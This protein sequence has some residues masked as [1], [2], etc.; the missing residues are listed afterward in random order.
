MNILYLVPYV[1]SLIR[2]RPYNLIRGLSERGH[3]ITLLTLWNSEDEHEAVKEL[4]KYCVGVKAVHLPKILSYWNCLKSLPTTTPLQAVYCWNP[5]LADYMVDQ[6][7]AARDKIDIVHVEHLRGAKYGLF[8]KERFGRSGDNTPPV[9]WDS[10]DSISH[11]FRQTVAKTENPF[12]RVLTRFELRRTEKYERYLETKFDKVLVTSKIDKG[13]FES[14]GASNNSN[15]LVLTNGV[16]LDYFKPDPS[17]GREPATIIVSGKL[18]YHANVSMVLYLLKE[19]MP[20]IWRSRPDV[21]LWVV[22]KDPPGDIREYNQHPKV[23]VTGTVPD[24]RL[25]LQRAA[26]AVAPITYGA[27]I[28]NKVL[29]AMA[30]STPV[31]CTPKAIS[32]LEYISDR[33][34][35]VKEKPDEFAG[36]VVKLLDDVELRKKIGVA[37]RR[38]VEK[39]HDWANISS[40]LENIYHQIIEN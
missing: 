23:E 14:L 38:Y 31:V 19:I 9:I 10:V 29:E 13:S 37:G 30:C 26:L 33:E 6:V 15:T 36:G 3:N 25:Y 21:K 8:L 12:S 4:K 1:P 11:L 16:D 17:V 39:H 34:I 28:Q 32:A 35:V 27:G 7:K 22:G 18:S 2:V 20:L 24:L 5:V 40:N